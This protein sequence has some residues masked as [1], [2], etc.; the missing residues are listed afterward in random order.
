MRESCTHCPIHPPT[1]ASLV[2]Y[3]FI[4]YDTTMH[5]ISIHIVYSKIEKHCQMIWYILVVACCDIYPSADL[6]KNIW[7]S[8][9]IYTQ[10]GTRVT[11]L[12]YIGGWTSVKKK[13]V[14]C[15]SHPFTLTLS[16][17]RYIR[18]SADAHYLTSD[19]RRYFRYCEYADLA[20][21]LDI[22]ERIRMLVS[23]FGCSWALDGGNH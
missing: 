5:V 2:I 17:R 6:R 11:G 21:S 13:Q 20:F 1:I 16:S 22:L 4:M 18:T 15:N 14:T 7:K 19:T 3:M 10:N 9:T 8:L 12:V 23:Y